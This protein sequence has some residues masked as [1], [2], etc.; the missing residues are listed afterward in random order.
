MIAH[1]GYKDGSGD[2]FISIDTD[3]CTQC[4]DKPCLEAC[5]EKIIELFTDDYDDE[6]VGIKASER[7]K[8]KYTCLT[9]KSTFGAG[10]AACIEACLLEAIEHSW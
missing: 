7:N 9:C 10:H 1:Y 2:F 3:K 8:I 5:P 6:V 4:S